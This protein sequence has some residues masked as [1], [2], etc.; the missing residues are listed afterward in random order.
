[1]NLSDLKITCRPATTRLGILAVILVLTPHLGLTQA[2]PAPPPKPAQT[3]RVVNMI[4]NGN[5]ERSSQTPNL[6]DGVDNTGKLATW[7]RTV[8]ALVEAGGVG[9]LLMPASIG[10]GDLNADGL[11]DLVVASPIGYFIM[12]I[13]SGTPEKAKFTFGEI[14]PIFVSIPETPGLG[15]DIA[16]RAPKIALA[17]LNENGRLDLIIGLYNGDLLFI[18]N[19]GTP[20]S[21]KWDQP[22]NY[23]AAL[24]KLDGNRPSRNL[25]APTVADWTKNG[26]PDLLLG[27][28]SYSANSIRAFENPRGG[29][30]NFEGVAAQFAAYGEGRE[31]LTPTVADMNGDG[32]LDLV[33]GD[34][35]GE[36]ALY[37]NPG[38][39]KPGEPIPFSS[40][41]SFGNTRS[42]GGCAAPVAID[43][44]KDGLIDLVIGKANGRVALALNSGTKEEP[45]FETPVELDGEAILKNPIRLPSGW[46]SSTGMNFGGAYSVISCVD[47]ETDP[48]SNPPEGKFVLRMGYE[49][50]P[51]KIL[52][53]ASVVSRQTGDVI[54]SGDQ[55][56]VTN[57][58]TIVAGPTHF[59]IQQNINRPLL[60]GKTYELTFKYRA[61]KIQAAKWDFV[62]GGQ[63][64]LSEDQRAVGGRVDATET[65]RETA[66]DRIEESG[67]IRNTATW[68]E[69]KKQVTIRFKN[70]DLADLERAS[71][72]SILIQADISNPAGALYLDDFVLTE[73]PGR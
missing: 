28:G 3:P 54:R 71:S 43:W 68:T 14:I 45:K 23:A 63:K 55:L 26:R 12:Y 65:I 32:N 25:I 39:L 2:P 36:I 18:P 62:I 64:V 16:Q 5:F 20:M 10:A 53:P 48:Q 34:R 46:T 60:V 13:N 40:V 58:E 31:Q 72:A 8:P 44:N 24:L 51:N 66:A 57:A 50:S 59:A 30:P 61:D 17:D 7:R 19:S 69:V 35:K 6:W 9:E 21:P 27:E 56:N 15:S 1:M 22:R 47:A 33:I 4:V 41:L 11:V 52:S 38:N 67:D 37:L 70:R 49:K 29:N 73:V 42:F